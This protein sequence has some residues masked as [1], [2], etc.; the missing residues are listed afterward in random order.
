MDLIDSPHTAAADL[1]RR[2]LLFN[3][4][5]SGLS[6][7]VMI[8]FGRLFLGA[9][10][11]VPWPVLAGIGV[12]LVL[13]AAGLM[14]NARRPQVSLTEARLAIASD[15]AWVAGSAILLLTRPAG[16]TDIGVWLIADIALIVAGFA[17]AQWLGVRRVVA[18]E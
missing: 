15:C 2:S 5:F 7:L 16:L 14:R 9:V 11:G 3:A 10:I 12:G 6:G 13:F 18:Q 17:L 1:L 8:A 4:A